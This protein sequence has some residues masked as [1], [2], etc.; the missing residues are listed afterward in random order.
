[1][2]ERRRSRC[3][4]ANSATLTLFASTLFATLAL[5]IATPSATVASEPGFGR[6]VGSD[7]SSKTLSYD[8]ADGLCRQLAGITAPPPPTGQLVVGTLD[9]K[10]GIFTWNPQFSIRPFTPPTSP[11]Q[12]VSPVLASI[13]AALRIPPVSVNVTPWITVPPDPLVVNGVVAGAPT[14]LRTPN[15]QLSAITEHTLSAPVSASVPAAPSSGPVLQFSPMPLA[16]RQIKAGPDSAVFLPVKGGP[17]ELVFQVVNLVPG[18]QLSVSIG[19]LVTMVQASATAAPGARAVAISVPLTT[20][21]YFTVTLTNVGGIHAPPSL[22]PPSVRDQVAVVQRFGSYL[23]FDRPPVLGCFTL[24]AYPVAMVYEPPGALSSQTYGVSHVMGTSVSTFSSS[25]SAANSPV[26]TPFSDV[27]AVI[28]AVGGLGQGLSAIGSSVP[29]A[30][31]AGAG[32]ESAAAVLQAVWGQSTTTQ[33]IT[34]HVSETHTLAIHERNA[35]TVSTQ[36]HLGPG[37]GDVIQFVTRPVFLW[38]AF[39]DLT[40]GSL[41]LTVAMISYDGIAAATAEA[42]RSGAPASVPANVRQLLLE[43][44]PAAAEYRSG[45]PGGEP[46]RLVPQTVYTW[47]GGLSKT[48]TLAHAVSTADE[49][50]LTITRNVTTTEQS[51]LLG[52][53]G[54]PAPRTGTTSMTTVNGGTTGTTTDTTTAVIVVLSDTGITTTHNTMASYDTKFGTF[55]YQDVAGAAPAIAGTVTDSGGAPVVNARVELRT[56]SLRYVTWTDRAGAYAFQAS[57]PPRGSHTLIAGGNRQVITYA[58]TPIKVNIVL[59]ART[60]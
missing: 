9:R 28:K 56:P 53:L 35:Q 50:T 44:D 5:L 59:G 26:N 8:K 11:F 6:R 52:M 16:T 51:G 43:D 32:M 3:S 4:V 40:T 25:D 47:T 27:N 36:L 37:R 7:T 1:M 13:L 58:G 39:S 29:W 48:D 15:V 33:T 10:T 54:L 38:L 22:G 19:N 34:E 41:Y 14:V 30:K 2:I 24:E 31:A 20:F 23:V 42:L 57:A 12:R 21:V 46:Q 49:K 60:R 18:D 17:Q 55:I 45:F